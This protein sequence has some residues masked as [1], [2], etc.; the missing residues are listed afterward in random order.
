MLGSANNALVVAADCRI[1]PPNSE[2]ER[3][4][5]DGAAALLFGNSDL[6]VE[7]ES[8]YSINSEFM[9]I[10]RNE[11]DTLPQTW[12]DR[13]VITKGYIGHMQET[14]SGLLKKYTLTPKD[15]DKVVLY[16]WDAR[17]HHELARRLGFDFD[18]QVQDSLLLSIGHTGTA[19]AMMML[20]AALEEAKPGDRILFAN[21]GDGAD[22]Y[23]LRATELIEKVKDRRGVKKHLVSKAMIPSYGKYLTF[24]NM[25]QWEVQ[26]EP[27]PYAALTMSWRDRDM[28]L[29]CEGQKCRHCDTVQFPKQR[30]CTWCQ[31]KDEFDDVLLADKRGTVFTYS[32]D[33]LT[34]VTPDPPNII[35]VI[36][37][38]GGG[39]MY[40]TMTDRD[41][42]KLTPD[43]RVEFTFR[44]LHDSQGM[45]NYFWRCR[46]IRV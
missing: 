38:D 17:R 46:P 9:D 22:A 10:W 20:I 27:P 11:D 43:M 33:Y 29:T 28:I 6:A 4:F 5:G 34:T 18:T 8:N 31:A 41:P 24:R 14:G 25:M 39:R 44:K 32:L 21:Y 30:V 40:T 1:P 7:I 15:F 23:I 37:L 2:F 16:A 42:E 26:R 45:H 3:L 12:E 19:S 13:F 35:A 36:N